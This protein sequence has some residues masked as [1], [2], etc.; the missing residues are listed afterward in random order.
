MGGSETATGLDRVIESYFTMWNEADADRRRAII[1]AT[2]TG[3]ASYVD[4]LLVA[5]GQQ[6]LDAMVA[7][8]HGQFPGPRFRLVGAPDAHHDRARWGWELVGP[9]GAP[10]VVRGIDV[11]VLA[12]D[13]RLRSV[14][15]FFEGAGQSA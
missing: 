11:A 14:T 13:G 3:E 5:E 2:W 1:A 7:G 9:D 6:G 15:G 4:P 8:V 12:D 10:P